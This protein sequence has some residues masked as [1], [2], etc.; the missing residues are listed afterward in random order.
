M[1]WHIN[2]AGVILVYPFLT[3]LFNSLT[4]LDVNTKFKNK[5]VQNRAVVL[6]N[7]I[8]TGKTRFDDEITLTIPKI[9]AG[10][11]IE[12]SLPKSIELKSEEIE[13]ASELL[14]AVINQWKKLG[15]ISIDGL[16]NT[17]LK[18]DGLLEYKDNAYQLTLESSGVDILLDYLPWS[19]NLAQLPWTDNII[20]VSWR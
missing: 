12:Q 4:Y 1:K 3:H 7:F 2:N 5:E 15:N 8:T 6:L 20:Y 14:N 17:F 19:I 16:R 13:I 10:S 18:R 11:S 9:L